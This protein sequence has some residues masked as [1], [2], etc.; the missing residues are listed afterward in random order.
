MIKKIPAD[1]KQDVNKTSDAPK[2]VTPSSSEITVTVPLQNNF[3]RDQYKKLFVTLIVAITISLIVLSVVF[4]MLLNRPDPVYFS[5]VYHDD[6]HLP[7]AVSKYSIV[8]LTPVDK[9]NMSNLEI[10]Q[11][12]VNAIVKSF[13]LNSQEYNAEIQGKR[14]Y[15]SDKAWVQYQAL[16]NE[17]VQFDTLTTRQALVSVLT[18][19][20]AP[21]FPNQGVLHSKGKYFWI[22]TLPV[23]IRFYGNESLPVQTMKLAV[24]VDRI[25]MANDVDGIKI[26]SIVA[27]EVKHIRDYAGR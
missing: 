3:Y 27:S 24:T 13:S 10:S 18:P 21:Q 7:P 5:A 14:K 8:P 25:S 1:A 4:F 12:L 23:R 2:A 20:S 9:P 6:K 16:V 26:D 11:W 19:I 22:A 15:F 17:M